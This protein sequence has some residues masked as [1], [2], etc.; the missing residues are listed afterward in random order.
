[1][2]FRVLGPLQVWNGAAWVGVPAARQRVVLAVLLADAGRSVSTDR[3]VEELWGATPPKRAGAAVQVY[4]GRLR[5]LLGAENGR[6]VLV[7]TRGSGYRL[8]VD[9]DGDI[10]SHVFERLTTGARTALAR[11][12]LESAAEQFAQALAWW[13]GPALADVPTSPNG[14]S[15][16][17]SARPGPHHRGGG[18]HWCAA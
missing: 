2:R 13:R 4:V 11:G 18:P 3:P 8:V 16:R 5:R 10:D 6:G 12:D 14:D 15:P 17:R 7:V 9:R 1:M